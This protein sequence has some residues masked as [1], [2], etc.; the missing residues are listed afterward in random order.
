MHQ[1]VL[2]IALAALVSACAAP[3]A[4]QTQG[5]SM[6]AAASFDYVKDIVAWRQ[7]VARDRTLPD[8]IRVETLK[9]DNN[10]YSNVH[11][12]G[13]QRPYIMARTAFQLCGARDCA[14]IDAGYDEEIAMRRPPGAPPL[15]P[16]PVANPFDAASWV[17]VQ[18]ALSRASLVAVTHEHP[19]HLAG[20]AR[21]ADPASVVDTLILT[22]VQHAGLA[23]YAPAGGLA[24][25]FVAFKPTALDRPRRVGPGLVMIPAAGHT[26]GSVMFY[27]RMAD[28]SEVLFI[29]DVAWAMANVIE[30]KSRSPNVRTVTPEDRPN[31]LAQV[32][33]LHALYKAQP[34]VL[35]IP[36]HDDVYIADLIAKGR[37]Q[38]GFR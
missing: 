7:L 18:G 38:Q 23:Q 15:P 9:R 8:E 2:A 20:L 11:E 13:E 10:L 33:A 6:A 19:D 21:H 16:G 1:L 30:N 25:A 4:T 35:I 26:A 14:V 27:Q 3:K 36:S 31:V 34:R 12:G 32:G 22:P 5:P 29:G 24:P 28:A 37:V 17:R